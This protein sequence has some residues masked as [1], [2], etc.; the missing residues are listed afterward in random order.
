MFNLGR[1]TFCKKITS[2]CFFK[3]SFQARFA[4]YIYRDIM[5]GVFAAKLRWSGKGS[6]VLRLKVNFHLTLFVP[7]NSYTAKMLAA[8]IY[9]MYAVT[10]YEWIEPVSV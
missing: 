5:L 4:L 2:Y 6:S 1:Q 3:Y 7:L 8:A 9:R 10:L